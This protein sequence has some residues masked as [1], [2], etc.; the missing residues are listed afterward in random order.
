MGMMKKI[1]DERY[2]SNLFRNLARQ[3]E[4]AARVK[5]GEK[6]VEAVMRF[7]IKKGNEPILAL[8]EEEIP[9]D[10]S[11]EVEVTFAYGDLIFSFHTRILSCL[12][13]ECEIERPEAV[14]SYFKRILS[15]YIVKEEDKI[16]VSL[17]RN[18]TSQVLN[19]GNGGL[20]FVS[21]ENLELGAYLK[22][23][24]IN[25]GG[26]TEILADAI[27]SHR[28]EKKDGSYV[29]GA[30]FSYIHVTDQRQL[31]GYIFERVYPVINTA[32]ECT[33]EEIGK[34]IQKSEFSVPEDCSKV[35][36]N[37]KNGYALMKKIT[38]NPVLSCSLVQRVGAE[39]LSMSSVIR[40]FD[41][42]FLGQQIICEPEKRTGVNANTEVYRA[43]S[44]FLLNNPYCEY[45]I[46]YFTA[47]FS[48]HHQLY[49]DIHTIIHDCSKFSLDQLLCFEYDTSLLA[50]LEKANAYLCEAVY[51]E[52]EF[53]EFSKDRCMPLEIECYGYGDAKQFA[54]NEVS[55]IYRAAGV[56][57]SRRLWR[58]QKDG[59]TIAYA[60]ASEYP[61]E[62]DFI[63]AVNA[64]R[65]FITAEGADLSE[66]FA[67]LLPDVA[68]F[69]KR[70]NKQ[71]FCLLTK[72]EKEIVQKIKLPGL[73]FKSVLC[74]VM[75]NREGL[76]EYRKLLMDNF[77]QDTRFYPITHPQLAIWYTEKVHPGTNFGNI[78]ATVRIKGNLDYALLEAAIN[79]IIQKN[80]GTR[81]RIIENDGKPRQSITGYKYSKVDFLDF[82]TIGG[83]AALLKWEQSVANI[84]LQL[85]NENL[86]QPTLFKLDENEG[87]FH[88][89]THHIICDGWSIVT[90]SAQIVEYYA[91]LKNGMKVGARNKPSYID[92]I[93]CEEEFNHSKR[94]LLQKEFWDKK[95][96]T[97]P[98]FVS[99]KPHNGGIRSTKAQRKS[100]ILSRELTAQIHNYCS[101]HK[102]S[103]LNIF[104]S[105][106][107]IYIFRVTNKKDIVLGT[108]I[109][110]RSNS[111]E[112]DT[113][114]MFTGMIP[115]RILMNPD[116]DYS[117]FVEMI[118]KEWILLLKN[119][120][121]PYN[122][123][124]K[125][126]REKHRVTDN[127]FDISVS[128]QNVKY[129]KIELGGD[130]DYYWTFNGS[131]TDSLQIHIR[132]WENQGEYQIDLD[133][134]TEEFT[135][136]EIKQV[137]NCVRNIL[138]DITLHPNKKLNQIDLL[139][140]DDKNKLLRAF[141]D[142]DC[143]YPSEKTL[144][145]VFEEQVEKTPQNTAVMYE[146]LKWTYA[147]LNE[148]A[149]QLARILKTWGVKAESI[150]AII[151]ERSFEMM[152]GILG[153]L[154]AGGAYLPISPEYPIE[155]IRYMLEDSKSPVVLTQKRLMGQ[156]DL[157][158]PMIDLN[159]ENA[160]SSDGSNLP[161][162]NTSKN[163]AYVIYTSGS[164]G[165]P[166]GVMIEHY[167]VIN[168][169]LWMQKMYSIDETDVIL[170]KTPFTFDVSVWELF[171]WSF[172]GAAVCFLEPGGEKD[173]E[174]IVKAIEGNKITTMH[175]VPSM[176]NAFL[177]YLES[178]IDFSRLGAL[179]QVFAS[180]EALHLH[181]VK[182]FNTLLNKTN[183]TKL[184][185]LYGPTEATVDVS[186]FDCS[187]GEEL[188]TIPIGKPID[189]TKLYV[190]DGENELLPIG[191]AGELHI[192]GDG[193]ARG[194][195]NRPELTAE[196]FVPCP[197]LPGERMYKTGDLACWMHDGNI[198]YLGR[199]DH[200]VKIRGLR[201]ELGE[202]ENQLLKLGFIKDAV[203]IDR[204]DSKGNK[205]LCAYIVTTR[206]YSLGEIKDHLS[207]ELPDYMI[208][209]QF[210]RLEKIPLSPNGK[211][212]R[213]ALPEP[214]HK[215]RSEVVFAAPGNSMEE[216]LLQIW[217]DTLN[218]PGI[219]IDHNFFE[220]GGDS[221]SAITL[222]SRIHKELD[223]DMPVSQV[224]GTPTIRAMAEKI[225]SFKQK[226]FQEIE[227]VDER[228]FYPVSSAQKRM[229]MLNQM[230]PQSLSYNMPGA[231]T[232]DGKVDTD[233]LKEAMLRLVD[234]H[235]SFRTS[236]HLVG[237]NIV[238]KVHPYVDFTI[239]CTE[240]NQEELGELIRE[241]I[242]PFDL[243][244]APLIRMQ[245]IKRGN[246]KHLLLIDMHHI[247]CDGISSRIMVDDLVALY[248]GRDLPRLKIQ[249]RDFAVWQNNLLKSETI[250][251]QEEYWLNIFKKEIPVLNMP[252]DYLRPTV[253]STAGAKLAFSTGTELT[254]KLNDLAAKT[255][256]TPYM[257]LL[258]AYNVLLSKYSGQED[259][260]VGSPVAGR[261]HADLDHI[262]GMFV[263]TLAVRNFP[264]P[265]KSFLEFLNEVRLNSI[266]AFE[267]QDYQ[268]E[269]L[270]EKLNIKRDIGRNPVFD[271]MFVYQNYSIPEVENQ[272]IKISTEE[273]ESNISKFDL[274]LQAR[275]AEGKLDFCFEYCTKL[276]KT[277]TIKRVSEH[278]IQLLT[279]ITENPE[280]KLCNL[281]MLT[282]QEKEQIL[283]D[284]NDTTVEKL[285]PVCIHRLFE[286]QVEKT[287]DRVALLNGDHAVTYREMN[288]RANQVAWLLKE[289][290]VG[291]DHIVGLL[292]DRSVEMMVGILGVLKAGG[293]YLPIDPEYP[294][295]RIEY[296]LSDSGANILLTQKNY[297]GRSYCNCE[298]IDLQ[299]CKLN[300]QR[301][302]NLNI[303]ESI[304]SLAY[305]IYT[306]GST[307]KPKGVMIEH[308]SVVNTLMYLHKEYPL[309]DNDVFLLKTTYTFDVSV[310]ELFGWFFEGGKLAILNKGEEKE[311]QKIL[312]A[313]AKYGVTHINFVPSMFSVFLGMLNKT[314]IE[315][316]NR[317][318]YIFVAGEAIS[319][320]TVFRFRSLIAKVKL[321]N[322]Y[323]PTEATIYATRYSLD[324]LSDEPN[325]PIGKPLQNLKA[326][327][328]D[329]QLNL[330]P[331]GVPGELCIAGMGLARGYLNKQDLTNEK[332]IM[333]LHGVEERIY[334]TGDL[335]RWMP[336]GNIEYLGR[337][338]NQI[339]IR[340]FRIELG[341]IES[342]LL[343]HPLVKEAVVVDRMVNGN[344][345]LCAYFISQ[346]DIPVKELRRHLQSELPEYM[347]PAYFIK[348]DSIPRTSSEKIDRKLLPEPSCGTE[349]GAKFA[350]PNSH[351]EILLS[352]VWKEVLGIDQV[353]T[354]EDFFELGGDSLAVIRVLSNIVSFGWD[355]SMQDFY[356]YRTIK[357]LA[358]KIDGNRE[359]IGNVNDWEADIVVRNAKECVGEICAA[360]EQYAHQGIL[361]TG[362]S[363]YLGIHV[364]NEII[365]TTD[366]KVFC[367]FRDRNTEEAEK[368]LI[369][370]LEFYSFH[371]LKDLIHQRIFV[372]LGDISS[373]KMGLNELDYRTI[374]E[375][376]DAVIHAA[377]VVKHY[378]EYE[379]F[380]RINL[381]GT[382]EVVHF[383]E[384]NKKR[385]CHISTMSVSGDSFTFSEQEQVFTEN[386]F[387]IGQ[388]YAENPY[389]KSK[390]LAENLVFKAIRNGLDAAVFRVGNLTGRY[391]DG[392]FQ[393]N[394]QENR[395]YNLL[396]SILGIGTIS[397]EM[398]EGNVEFTPVDYCSKAI[399]K[400]AGLSEIRNKVF[401]LF[402]DKVLTVGELNRMFESVGM[403]LNILDE[404]SFKNYIYSISADKEKNELLDGMIND[405]NF[406]YNGGQKP[407]IK[408]SS[409]ITNEYLK[410]LEFEW[411]EINREYIRKILEH[412]RERDFLSFSYK[413]AM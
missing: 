220:E 341:E 10:L 234:R 229:F 331:I 171:W 18:Q 2:I 198:E 124:L 142:T 336:D 14:V 330:L 321:E 50:D 239:R 103:P 71:S 374:S 363:G 162:Q 57:A 39:V 357:E 279:R 151:A 197:Y 254:G 111:R 295:E 349:A 38:G 315:V 410:Q 93:L 281:S 324:H 404:N 37:F 144:V 110:N 378:G 80:D 183:G 313:I 206:E 262:V 379:L 227:P 401:H 29:L 362:A 245:I 398:L 358:E 356:Q 174:K 337:I 215:V 8:L 246:K 131:Q 185:N 104:L 58:I 297:M 149:N 265:K 145:Q 286:S 152:V 161:L 136:E 190:L 16:F 7:S 175:F 79:L 407:S 350:K 126:Y 318:K 172:Q 208:P 402:N 120:K 73:T 17:G 180:G 19:I 368:R 173:P 26:K 270:V 258:A 276:F 405:L 292:V 320:E 390:F 31:F 287:P 163:L 222:I 284:F 32:F 325:V 329:K 155:R 319:R 184:H 307:G 303:P 221:L 216:Q 294:K 205:Y 241:F 133:Y 298:M 275:M 82:S 347:V 243:G 191:V 372:V 179:R 83:E 299:D 392:H 150:V 85:E 196:K 317:L 109:L 60:E 160:Y 140:E 306:S 312:K 285:H 97:M 47:D 49:M 247:I 119:Q 117:A 15:R 244:V 157:D 212:D 207:R 355:I 112:K 393:K 326:Y 383:C 75:M 25:L 36:N 365:E 98:E 328:M 332:F 377:A 84:P 201:I 283:L 74:R 388:N 200:Q 395:F 89:K 291:R 308:G 132:D 48:W 268:F 230:E 94:F 261:S 344:K 138:A 86:Y 333:N 412:M 24:R 92:Y 102:V 28:R 62:F 389:V 189:N 96:E 236:F 54:L 361:L 22:N 288:D 115:V 148:K 194:Y 90:S 88:I 158:C 282:D 9:E 5:F 106:V 137:F 177:E 11:G 296:M 42:T 70:T 238:Q 231:I 413:V 168:R 360:R 235:E 1:E 153:I 255:Q 45:F 169:I 76:A 367:I 139:S 4:I 61:E 302:E 213:K 259:I 406:G 121:Y 242:Q 147:E 272:D 59:M 343:Q 327:V 143:E 108:P 68:E 359:K 30:R 72:Q 311:P 165:K 99:F 44:D 209:S 352:E 249:Y 399:V 253:Q 107:Y 67:A 309:L 305:I 384:K 51:G 55:Q 12:D 78:L 116:L 293:A 114:G 129:Q 156:L 403:K 6:M 386:D 125:N 204:A 396:R 13:H 167:S 128:Y 224:F 211:A 385:L 170:Q 20:S 43:I 269:E 64:C 63:G 256:T 35:L 193:L 182:K 118:S 101:G 373:K 33:Q 346:T 27:I 130:Y 53:L 251:K 154:K 289:K 21:E 210:M 100:F 52:K 219:G 266:Q 334:K 340:G 408:L 369:E 353:G 322:L 46:Q 195:L 225:N 87:G 218:V 164:T 40:V 354:D 56:N 192:A 274:T 264:E 380:E 400:L 146:G 280:E 217:A 370:Y 127:L 69:Y 105:A 267:N 202:I 240:S 387:Y 300:I 178:G 366:A 188:K 250:K 248:E 252:T 314:D 199:I 260:V 345:C 271:T 226:T 228:E 342:R 95:F 257:I 41:R 34:L 290:G 304:D 409:S 339:K 91:M 375:N 310:A 382:E 381:R 135:E 176:L 348:L 214:D 122:L 376:T 233:R 323:G 301:N 371:Q 335:V 65:V 186:Y 66:V 203:V 123:I 316:L 237:E 187:S 3:K 232:V 364:L 338:D 113:F 273:L 134:L 411:P 263:N 159:S 391:A 166:K 394:I 277:E 77:V 141:N 223:I 397:T 181:Q 81:I 23:I 278:L 351:T